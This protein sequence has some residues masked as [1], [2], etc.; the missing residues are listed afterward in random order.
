MNTTIRGHNLKVL[1]AMALLTLV[2][3]SAIVFAVWTTATA[4]DRGGNPE[5]HG[6]SGGGQ[7][8]TQDPYIDRHAEMIAGY[9]EGSLR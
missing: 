8:I 2:L 4:T 9:Y 3:L 5:I 7:I 6:T 1:A